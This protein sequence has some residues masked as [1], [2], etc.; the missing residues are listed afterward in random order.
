MLWE[1][2]AGRHP[3]WRRSAARDREADRPRRA[4]ARRAAARPAEAARR[5]RRPRAR[6]RP[7]QPARGG[8]ARRGAP[9]R[10]RRRAA[11]SRGARSPCL[12]AS[13]RRR[14]AAARR[15]LGRAR[16]PAGSRPTLPFFPRGWPP[17]SPRLAGAAL[18]RR[19]R[20]SGSRFALAV[21][22]FPLGNIS[23]G[24][25][26]PLRRCS[27]SPGSCS[28]GASRGRRCS[29][30]PGPLLAPL[31]GARPAAARRRCRRA[32][33]RRAARAGGRRAARRRRSSPGSGTA[34]AARRAAPP[35][36]LGIAGSDGPLAVAAALARRARPAP[37]ALAAR[38]ARAR[39][40]RGR[41][42]VRPPAR[43]VGRRRLR[44]ALLVPRR[45][46]PVPG[47]AALP[48]VARR[49]GHRRR[50]SRSS[51]GGGRCR[52]FPRLCGGYRRSGHGSSR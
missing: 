46:S 30:S 40:R 32:A 26:G 44:R 1:A 48:L 21:P 8:R 31:G 33:P 22:V 6:A 4:L 36:G 14:R 43:P 17:G 9:R 20:G 38:G 7:A 50:C 18:A 3:F 39:G 2:L 35:L 16:S 47:A 45:C 11:R 5:P 28:S 27:P 49:L 12:G 41:D 29:S 10:R 13:A 19:R 51:P 37:P 52:A 23:L 42:P 15:G 34:P 24:P 25:R